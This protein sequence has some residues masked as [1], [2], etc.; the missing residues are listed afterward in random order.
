[1]K[2]KIMIILSCIVF[3]CGI[4]VLFYPAVRNQI[5][6]KEVETQFNDFE[7]KYSNENTQALYEYMKAYNENLFK[8]H[9]N[10]L[11]DPFSYTQN[12]IDLSEYGIDDGIVG[13]ITI[14]K[15]NISLPILLGASEKN[16]LHGATHLTET[17]YPI[18]GENTNC[19]IAAHRGTTIV[20]FRNIQLLEVGDKVE[21]RNF[22]ETL[23]YE[24]S[25]IEIINPTDVDKLLIRE[26]E[27]MVTLITCHPYRSNA[28]RYVVFCK[29]VTNS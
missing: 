18:G 22:C 17:S 27:D 9:Q 19:V 12:K 2:K 6:N 7:E 4:S 8:N 25:E 26:G 28:Q 29:R 10:T 11:V 13:Y 21:I 20:M 24:V 14:S 1:M 15:M 16:M 23:D 5:Y 3:L